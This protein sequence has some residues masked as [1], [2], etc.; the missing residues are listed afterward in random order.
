AILEFLNEKN[1]QANWSGSTIEQRF[2]GRRWR[3][4]LN[5]GI[6]RNVGGVFGTHRYADQDATQADVRARTAAWLTKQPRVSD[7]H[8]EGKETLSGS[9]SVDDA[10]LYVVLRWAALM[11]LDLSGMKNL[12]A[13]FA[14]MEQ[15]EG[16]KAALR[17][18]G[19]LKD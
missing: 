3:A 1:P 5:A 2:E 19:L 17:G 7:Q 18:E 10:Y 14:R 11:K 12:N 13:F 9:L 16:V 4:F 15:N 8:L 6:H